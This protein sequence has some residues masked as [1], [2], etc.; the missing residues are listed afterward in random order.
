[1]RKTSKHFAATKRILYTNLLQ[2]RYR[3]GEKDGKRKKRNK[4][5]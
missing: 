4:D 1:M 2:L 3:E 5:Y